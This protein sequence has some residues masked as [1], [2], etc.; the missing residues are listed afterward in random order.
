[1]VPYELYFMCIFFL[2]CKCIQWSIVS[3]RYINPFSSVTTYVRYKGRRTF[4]QI[5]A[6]ANRRQIITI[7]ND[8]LS[9]ILHWNHV[10]IPHFHSRN[11]LE[12]IACRAT[13][14]LVRR[15]LLLV[16]VI[17]I[18][19]YF[20]SF[21][22]VATLSTSGICP[23]SNTMTSWWA[24]WRL[25]SPA[26]RVFTQAFIRAQIK[27]NIKAP[28]HWPLCGEFTGDRRIPRTKGQ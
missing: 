2:P 15:E 27:E 20:H 3:H 23:V 11:A 4:G 10:K 21:T 14:I 5:M 24:R 13:T 16:L 28:R 7:T 1:M 17:A 18:T 6:C 12:I 25:K 22:R 26:S 19:R 8:N 9:L